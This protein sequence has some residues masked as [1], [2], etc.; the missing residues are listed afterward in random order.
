MTKKKKKQT[1]KKTE[2]REKQLE[3]ENEQLCAEMV[4]VEK[5]RA[6]G[7]NIPDRLKKGLT[8]NH[9][10]IRHIIRKFGLK[11]EKFTRKSSNYNTYIGIFK[12]VAKSRVHR[13]F[14][15]S[16][17]HQEITTDTSEFKYYESGTNRKTKRKSDSGCAERSD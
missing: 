8:V 10:K 14:A 12:R 6:L 9:K 1:Q 13:R 17:A 11:V 16:V 4:F 15:T 3:Q 2:T 7:T 5:L